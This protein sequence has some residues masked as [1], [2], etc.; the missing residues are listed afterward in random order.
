MT[1]SKPGDPT[2]PPMMTGTGVSAPARPLPYA[3]AG[4]RNGTLGAGDVIW[5]RNM[6]AMDWAIVLEPEVPLRKAMQMAPLALVATGDCIGALT[7]PQVGLMFRWPDSVHVNGA[8]AGHIEVVA[9]TTDP[10]EIPDWIVLRVY[11]QLK[12]DNDTEPG[13]RPDITSL[14]EEGCPDLTRTGMIESY[15]RH[16]LTWLNT[17]TEDGFKP[18]HNAWLQRAH[19]LQ[20]PFLLASPKLNVHG[21]F[22]G[23]DEDGN[24]LLTD[25]AGTTQLVTLADALL[26]METGV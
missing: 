9:S 20:E 7:P 5:A 13:E 17:W 26:P 4:A 1:D 6:S 10:D 23:L 2:F 14:D 3:T 12:R 18:I 11:V 15:S 24:M 21:S 19:G 8:T 22:T 16:F 25:D